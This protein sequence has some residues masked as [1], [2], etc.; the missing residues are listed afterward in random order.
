[1]IMHGPSLTLITFSAGRGEPG[2]D[3]LIMPLPDKGQ[4]ISE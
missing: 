2:E 4:L 1:M 3:M